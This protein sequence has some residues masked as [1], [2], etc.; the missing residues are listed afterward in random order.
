MKLTRRGTA[1]VAV[2]V[3]AALQS[4][5]FG[6][7]ALNFVAA[8][9]VAALIAGVFALWSAE[10]PSLERSSV[11]PGFPGEKRRETISIDG[12]GVA[13]VIDTLP[14]GIGGDTINRT[15]SLPARLDREV[16]YRQRGVYPLRSVTV[17]Q[18]DPLGLVATDIELEAESDVVV[19]PAVYELDPSRVTGSLSG[20]G[21]S[22]PGDSFDWLREY[23]NGDPLRRVHWKS[24][25]KHDE[26][27]VADSGLEGQ[28]DPI[29]IVVDGRAKAADEL[30]AAAAS[31][32]LPALDA[33]LEVSLTLP[34]DHVTGDSGQQQRE[35]VLLA[36]AATGERSAWGKAGDRSQ[37]SSNA[38]DDADVSILSDGDAVTVRIDDRDVPLDRLRSGSMIGDPG[39]RSTTAATPAV[40]DG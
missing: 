22:D 14:E 27:L 1:V 9:G 34:D 2:V 10:T 24:S 17:R 37:S 33:G 31:F 19:Y 6:E 15:V 38:R 40:I 32:A 12:N 28:T 26:L 4:Y 23:E 16:S 18:R 30:A 25:A 36:L 21:R 3:F 20:V 11:R 39:A 7:R 5:F 8:P 35:R 29:H 13:T